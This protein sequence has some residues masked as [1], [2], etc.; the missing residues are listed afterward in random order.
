MKGEKTVKVSFVRRSAGNS[1]VKVGIITDVDTE[2]YSVSC[3]LADTLSLAR[4]C[5][6]TDD[7]YCAISMDYERYRAMRRSLSL[8]SIGDN[9]KRS[10]Y[11]KLLRSGFSKEV[12]NECVLE[13]LRLGYI[14]EE[15]QIE[16]AVLS[17]ANRSLRGR[18][19]II[20]KL[21]S[22][23]YKSGTVCEIIDKLVMAGEIDFSDNFRRLCDKRGV[24]D[25]E[26]RHALAYKY[27]YEQSEFD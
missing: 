10:L 9:T 17:E 19:Y 14:D 27:G 25:G 12:A 26:E 1:R 4:G 2:V 7:A 3:A 21:I 20:S 24:Y 11:L 18:R 13:C 5:E 23:G 6:I 16:R 15:R 8:L 22:K